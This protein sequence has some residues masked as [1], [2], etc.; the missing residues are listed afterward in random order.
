LRWRVE[1]GEVEAEAL[2]TSYL[3]LMRH[4]A[5]I[6]AGQDPETTRRGRDHVLTAQGYRDAEAV[7]QRLAETL[8]TAH[9]DPNKPVR[10][11]RIRYAGKVQP[12]GRLVCDEE[13]NLEPQATAAVVARQLTLGGIGHQDP[14]PWPEISQEHFPASSPNA[15]EQACRAVAELECD[16]NLH[17]G[18]AVLVVANSP[19]IDWIVE[20]LL[21]RPIA[22]GRGEVMGLAGSTRPQR[23][24][25]RP[26]RW[27]WELQWTVGP[28]EETTIEDLRSKIRS[29][30]DTAKFLG[31]FITALVSFV[32]GKR[33]DALQGAA[34]PTKAIPIPPVQDRLW[35]VT[36][37]LL[38]AAA[39]LCFAGLFF[40]D[41]LLMPDRYWTSRAR[42]H[43]S[44]RVRGVVER[45]P[46]SAAWVLQQN[47]VRVWN[48]LVVPAIGALGLA[49][50]TFALLVLVNPGS[51]RDLFRPELLGIAVIAALAGSY[52]FV[53]RPR[54]GV[55][56]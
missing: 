7:G 45:P 4:G 2:A 6:K 46:S 51:G 28:S 8:A 54:L 17:P 48:R 11:A 12:T 1:G 31:T 53:S 10:V 14:E 37:G 56:D 49:L 34:D 42:G 15:A 3:L 50:V 52:L 24:S 20:R 35:L 16:P 32:L 41:G 36:V 38:L 33:L 30:M 25:Q 29:K 18:Q 23:R 19:Q 47:M 40:Y 26:P 44:R 55:Q 5:G 27:R 21:G 43:S 22:V 9:G 39:L 13:V